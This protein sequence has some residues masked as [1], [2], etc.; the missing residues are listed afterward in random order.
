[1]KLKEKIERAVS[2]YDRARG[3][4]L[5][6]HIQHASSYLQDVQTHLQFG[7]GHV[8]V[9][10]IDNDACDK[11]VSNAADM[12]IG[13]NTEGDEIHMNLNGKT[14]HGE[15]PLPADTKLSGSEGQIHVQYFVSSDNESIK[16]VFKTSRVWS[17]TE[18][19][20]SKLKFVEFHL[21]K[22]STEKC[23]RFIPWKPMTVQGEERVYMPKIDGDLKN[24]FS[25]TKAS[26]EQ[27]RKIVHIVGR[28][29]A[30]IIK[31]GFNYFDVKSE[32]VGYQLQGR[33][34]C[35]FMLDLGS[36]TKQLKPQ[37]EL[38]IK[39]RIPPEFIKWLMRY[40]IHVYIDNE[41]TYLLYALL[42]YFFY[43]Q[44]C[45]SKEQIEGGMKGHMTHPRFHISIQNW[46][47]NEIIPQTPE[48]PQT[49]RGV[50]A[51]TCRAHLYEKLKDFFVLTTMKED[52]FKPPEPPKPP[53]YYNLHYPTVTL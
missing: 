53:P 12:L 17:E 21:D 16:L 41:S 8:N 15:K 4:L 32:N 42:L 20:Y 35:I 10:V 30:C 36:L 47:K 7:S 28:S 13:L 24:Y 31:N 48:L 34:L 49:P 26:E 52:D 9:S 11:L 46:H 25:K 33:Q 44:L 23:N 43:N 51:Q 50:A 38:P 39:K 1:M 22:K 40:H 3:Y 45:G 14:F 5:R 6:K 27:A 19:H 29:I 37:Q 2:S 18:Q